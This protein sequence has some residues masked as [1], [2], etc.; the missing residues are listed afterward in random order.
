M[1]KSF[2]IDARETALLVVDMQN[3]FCDAGGAMARSGANTLSQ[4]EIVPAVRE[5]VD[6]CRRAGIHVIWSQQKHFPDDLTRKRH[7]IP[8][9]LDKLGVYPCLV[10]TEDAEIVDALKAELRPEDDVL[11]KH[12]SSCFYSTTLEVKL[13]MRGIGMLIIC[14]VATNY[15]VES[16]IRDAYARDYDILVVEDCVACPWD[17]LQRATLKNVEMFYGKV[18]SLQALAD[19]LAVRRPPRTPPSHLELPSF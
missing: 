14:G 16:T 17:D 19:T 5:L 8:S 9:H 7:R 11:E 15:C 13:R 2:T 10:G 4:M 3:G 12:R 6:V 18:M 1:E